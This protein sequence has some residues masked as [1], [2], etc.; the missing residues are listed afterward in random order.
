MKIAVSLFLYQKNIYRNNRSSVQ[1]I[2]RKS[3]V[4]GF[5]LKHLQVCS[6]FNYLATLARLYTVVCLTYHVHHDI[7]ET[8]NGHFQNESSTSSLHRLNTNPPFSMVKQEIV[9][10]ATDGVWTFQMPVAINVVMCV[11]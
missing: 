5:L 2:Y 9:T 6:S 10:F 1:S 11:S 7:P 8:D 3:I 4:L